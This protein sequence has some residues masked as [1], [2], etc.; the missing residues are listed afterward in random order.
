[1]IRGKRN[2]ASG[3]INKRVGHARPVLSN[4]KEGHVLPMPQ[5]LLVT[6]MMQQASGRLNEF[7]AGEY[8]HVSDLV[9]RCAR[10]IAISRIT[11]QPIVGERVY[12]SNEITYAIGNAIHDFV[13]TRLAAS[14]GENLYGQWTCLCGHLESVGTYRE[15]CHSVCDRCM[16]PQRQY[17]ELVIRNDDLM[18]TASPDA[19]FQIDNALYLAEIKSTTENRMD[20]LERPFPDHVIQI[21]LYWYLMRQAQY[22]LYDR[23]SILY[24]RK[25][26]R[27]KTPYKEF[28]IIPSQ[29]IQRLDDY[30]TDARAVAAARDT[31]RLP[32]RVLC[33][34]P[35]SP[36]A[37][38]CQF[39]ALCFGVQNDTIHR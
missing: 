30:L 33:P 28:T 24:V 31:G 20:S 21:L 18:L 3:A 34:T 29:N 6:T 14:A 8:M 12:D 5:T 25:E 26:H 36:V 22:S 15:Y 39:C 27:F 4:L 16:T 38:K 7:R 11:G 1:M 37:K 23:V 9:G 10:R 13:R 2:G 32:A 35:H 17:K 19:A